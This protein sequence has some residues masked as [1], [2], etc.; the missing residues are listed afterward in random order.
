VIGGGKVYKERMN[1]DRCYRI[2]LTEIDQSFECDTFFP[3]ID[4]QKF[5]EVSDP[6]VTQEQQREE[7][8]TYK[9]KIYEKI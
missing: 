7:D 6:D 3:K 4:F 2:Y 9:F 8:V 1:S 5:K